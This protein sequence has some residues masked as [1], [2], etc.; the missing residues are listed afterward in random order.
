MR[1][2][3]LFAGT[4][5]PLSWCVLASTS[6]LARAGTEA[7][8]EY[9]ATPEVYLEEII[10]TAQKREERLIDVPAPITA[11][12]GD[13]ISARGA[14]DL[15]SLQFSV[16]GFSA[17][18]YGPG[19]ERAQL[20]GIS[21]NYG[22]ET[23]GRY[24]D[25]MPI[26]AETVGG[27]PDIRLIDMQRVEVL[28]GPQPTLYGDGSMGGTIR[29]VT[30]SPDLKTASGSI[31]MDGN[32][33]QDG[34]AGYL[35][36]GY[37]S[38]PLAQDRVGLRVAA[39]YERQGGWIDRVPTG[40]KNI[41]DYEI[42]TIRAKLLVKLAEQSDLSFM[43]M[44]QKTEN[45]NQ[46]FGVDGATHLS[47]PTP[48]D[49]DY[50][51]ANI[52][53]RINLGFAE[54]VET[55]GYVDYRTVSQFDLSPFYV[56]VV[57]LLGFPPGYITQIADTSDSDLKTYTNEL[58]LVSSAGTPWS[59]AAGFDYRKTTASGVLS[60]PTTPNALPFS[61]L[62]S[63][64][65]SVD[66][67]WALW[68]EG[69]Y[70]F[71]ERLTVKLG[72]RYYHDE[73]TEKGT[74]ET[75]G[76]PTL[77]NAQGTF[78]STN[79]R[80]NLS[81]KVGENQLI[82][83][84]A[85]KGFR[86]GGFNAVDPEL[87][88]FSPESLWTYELGSKGEYWDRKLSLEADVYY[89][90]WR[91]VQDSFTLP[92]GLSVILNGG[93]VKG[94][95]VDFAA[96]LAPTRDLHIGLTYGWNNLAYKEVPPNADKVVGDPPDFAVRNAWSAFGDYR[97]PVAAAVSAY[98]RVDFAHKGRS[99]EALRTPPYNL[100]APIQAQDLLNLRLGLTFG[101]YDASVYVN[102]LT[103]ERAPLAPPLGILT[104]NVEQRPRVIGVTVRANF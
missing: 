72:A 14:P 17:L 20:R 70:T 41:N 103:N 39:G 67:I 54:L 57:Q 77:L 33:V 61:L 76:V 45:P 34:A 85:A 80:L 4:A 43:F 104:E 88:T 10:V 40:E 66:K 26:N 99:Q 63:D 68:V 84:E 25:E 6:G 49:T 91:G 53:L 74:V 92:N 65:T 78:T 15:E 62:A 16:P 30:A 81:Y 11:V 89:S 64:F 44:H 93:H 35:V 36:N 71:N 86:S 29:Y 73:T 98:G 5:L 51:L 87:P 12:T 90:D 60:T 19:A 102:N 18:R 2:R 69:G 3:G 47:V 83:A 100:V 52:V 32:S 31:T 21:S 55:P 8:G 59:W 42:G 28:R 1:I 46:A 96:T 94:E 75:F 79:P 27:S 23:V 37:L 38:T 101:N 58:R 24:L 56:P 22:R 82:Y 13:D 9:S 7:G 48:L 97:H 50:N 95:G